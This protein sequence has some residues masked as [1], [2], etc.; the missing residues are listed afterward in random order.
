[1]KPPDRQ[2]LK[3]AAVILAS[4][5]STTT[6]QL[7]ELQSHIDALRYTCRRLE[8]LERS[9]RLC[10]E[11]QWSSAG[12]SIQNRIGCEIGDVSSTAAKITA[13]CKTNSD[14]TPS[15]PQPTLRDVVGELRQLDEEFDGYEYDAKAKTLSVKTDPI[16][17]EDIA[18][19][20]FEIELNLTI[21]TAG[22]CPSYSVK[23]LEPNPAGSNDSVT[24]PHVRDERLCEGDATIPIKAALESGRVCDFFVL[25]RS[26]LQH[27]NASSPHVSLDSWHGTACHDCG[28]TSDE[29]SYCEGCS[30][31]FCE[32]CFNYCHR[33]NTGLC[34]GCLERCAACEE[35][36]CRDCRQ[37]C[38]TCG[39][40]TCTDCLEDDLCPTCREKAEE[41]HEQ[42][43]REQR[44]EQQQRDAQQ[45]EADEW[46]HAQQ[47]AQ[48]Q[49]DNAAAAVAVADESIISGAAA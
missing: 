15:A 37:S 41:E 20:P 38:R 5:R 45:R 27:Y 11:K 31:D 7:A 40:I 22:R 32:E 42:R 8:P 3:L 44:Q 19:G 47:L 16:T 18:L 13:L 39:E 49:R 25:V 24:H 21:S 1:M 35:L 23:A 14:V 33:C 28:Y 30:N 29:T 34:R 26:V 10:Q 9:L 17:L 46:T 2:L 4:A 6:Q 43:E 48:Q 12:R 36:T